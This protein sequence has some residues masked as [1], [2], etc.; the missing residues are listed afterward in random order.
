MFVSNATRGGKGFSKVLD[1]SER[2]RRMQTK[3]GPLA[4]AVRKPD[5]TLGEQCVWGG[6]VVS[7]EVITG[8]WE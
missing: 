1:A 3:K 8:S 6:V 7:L 4:W 2:S 5:V